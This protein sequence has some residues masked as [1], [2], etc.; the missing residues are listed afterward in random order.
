VKETRAEIIA[1]RRTREGGLRILLASQLLLIALSPFLASSLAGNALYVILATSVVLSG[2][3]AASE[4]R[5]DLATALLLAVP[6]VVMRWTDVFEHGP[7]FDMVSL[8]ITL[9]FY[10]YAGVLVLQRVMRTEKV[11]ADE[12]YGALSVYILIGIIWGMFYRILDQLVPGSFRSV[13]EHL[14]PWDLVYFSFTTLMTVG[15]GD[16]QPVSPYAKALAILE[17][18]AG[19]L[20]TAVFISRLVGLYARGTLD[21]AK[22]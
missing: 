7:I 12:I 10:V 4:R 5:R 1:L 16:I 11:T 21:R 19:V 22:D 15:Y 2:A 6:A 18:L 8:A 17:G 14:I 13:A 20:Y 9:T 3:Y